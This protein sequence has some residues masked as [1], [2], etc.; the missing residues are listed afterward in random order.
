MCIILLMNNEK[1][2][3]PKVLAISDKLNELAGLS[4][5]HHPNETAAVGKQLSALVDSLT[6]PVPGMREVVEDILKRS[7]TN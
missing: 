1:M 2:I 6:V 7:P 4:Q 5:N 3:N